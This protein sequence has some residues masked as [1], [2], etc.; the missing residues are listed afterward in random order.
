[1]AENLRIH[2]R[3][4]QAERV[5]ETTMQS[6]GEASGPGSGFIH[7]ALIY[8]SDQEFMDV[9]LPFVEQGLSSRQPT[10]VAVPHALLS[11]VH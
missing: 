7:Q 11:R 5:R 10:L 1:M 4:S 8:D 2:W 6:N 9:A 3:Q